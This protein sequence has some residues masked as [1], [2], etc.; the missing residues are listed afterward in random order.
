MHFAGPTSK[1]WDYLVEL[2]PDIALLQE[3]TGM[4]DDVSARY[5]AVTLPTSGPTSERYFYSTAVLAGH[6]AWATE[7]LRSEA[8]WVDA[9]LARYAGNLISTRVR[10]GDVEI[11]VIS[12]HSPYFRLDQTQFAGI[13]TSTVK[14]T[15]N[16]DV[17]LA[18]VLWAALPPSTAE[19]WIVGGDFNLS[20]TFDSWAGG[21]R[22]NREYLD[23][24]TS[25]GYTECL[26]A[27]TGKLTPTFRNRVGGAVL[28]QIDHIF[29]S[30]QLAKRLEA[31]DV[32]SAE[33]VFDVE[34]SDHLPIIADFA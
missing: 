3:V 18:D 9:E 12:V 17:Y 34:L 25:S 10:L 26:R 31:C 30:A 33:R 19:P 16:P 7:R 5:D 21:P 6:C 4:P 29:V 8:G 15:Q 24:M 28:H 14:L 20:E 22:G 1:A 32:G 13:D 2:E 23:R 11:R 27:K